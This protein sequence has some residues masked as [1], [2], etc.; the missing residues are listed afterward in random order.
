MSSYTQDDAEFLAEWF[1][2]NRMMRSSYGIVS[3]EIKEAFEK[4]DNLRAKMTKGMY[5]NSKWRFKFIGKNRKA[6]VLYAE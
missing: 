1:N 2:I 5:E 6:E 3:K 4:N